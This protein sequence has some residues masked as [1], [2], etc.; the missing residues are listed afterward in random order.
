[1]EQ[2]FKFKVNL[3]G[4]IDILSNHLYSSPDVFVRELLQNGTDAISARISED[5]SFEEKD[6]V[7][8]IEVTDGERI[9]FRDN[10]TGLTEDEIHRFLSVIGQSSKYDIE[11]NRANGDYIGRFGIGLLSCFMVT[12]HITVRTRSYKQPDRVLEWKGMADGTYTIT[13][14]CDTI[15]IGTEIIILN[16]K[17][18]KESEVIDD[19]YNADNI[20][21]LVYYYGLF[22]KYPVYTIS[23]GEKTRLNLKFDFDSVKNKELCMNMGKTFLGESFLDCFTLK[24]EKGLFSGI[25]YILP[26]PV[27]ATA[28][29]MHRIYL[30]NM[31]LTESGEKLIPEWAFFIRC[32]IN[33]DKLKPTSSREDFYDDD[34]LEQARNEIADCISDYF[35][36]L[37]SKNKKL[38]NE[39]V[40]IHNLAVK[41]VL[42]SSD[43]MD[44]ILLP[45]IMF[46]TSLGEMNGSEISDFG[47]MV[48]YTLD[49][50]QFR[51]LAP[52]YSQRSELLINAGYVYENSILGKIADK[53]RNTNIEKLT[54][55]DIDF[56]LD[57]SE[58]DGDPAADKML[59]IMSKVLK[60]YDCKAALKEFRPF[61][62]PALYTL[63][64]KAIEARQIRRSKESANAVFIDMLSSFEDDIKND[65][66]ACLYLNTNNL[67]I[68]RLIDCD[69]R[70]KII[71]YTEILY[72][73][74]LLSG[75]FPLLHDEM[76]ILN[77][78]LFKLMEE[79]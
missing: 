58:F 68:R 48:F 4:M 61:D 74:S 49:V 73:Q 72:V 50:N 3:G 34:L 1:M 13:D 62:I 23:G 41:S 36:E 9:V 2:D 7:I 46:E 6:A 57:D 32:I 64:E 40:R 15:P 22:L 78:N 71:C 24:S 21:N 43:G 52:L 17:A 37:E 30:K 19:Y 16:N 76:K 33:T 66:A 31:L 14:A 67:I 8:E 28:H 79:K 70:D 29:N 44:D 63:N 53:S 11:N 38:L 27:S 55:S 42:A 18:E 59:G 60:K 35:E 39:I 5:S 51:Q 25:A 69:D 45:Y 75:H 26:Y 77:E 47:G 54:D 56:M 12:E 65:S 20:A 10:G